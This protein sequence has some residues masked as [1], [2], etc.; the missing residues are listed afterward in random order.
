MFVFDRFELDVP[1]YELRRAGRKVRLQR[2]PMD[3]LILLVE[4]RGALVTR[5]E[6][7][8]RIWSADAAVDSQSSINTAIRK[9]RQALG[10]DGE[11]PRFVETVVGKGYRFI[12]D[13]SACAQQVEAPEGLPPIPASPAASRSRRR[14]MAVAAAGLA[15]TL[16]IAALAGF[17]PALRREP[18]PLRILPFSALR[19]LESWPTFSPDGS[20]VAFGWAEETSQ[21]SHLY[22]QPIDGGSPVALTGG[23]DS[24]TSPSWS[25][26][27]RWI[28]FLRSFSGKDL[29]SNV[30]L[31]VMPASGGDGRRIAA[32]A[33]PTGY[34][35]SWTPDGQG[36]VVMDS[37][38][39]GAPPSLY[40]V[41]L[42]SGQKRRITTA[43]ATGT[44][45][46]CPAFSPD[47]RTLA[48]LRNT[49]SRRLSPL[50]V[51]GVTSKGLP[52]G[53]PRQIE[54]GPTEFAD[55]D[56]SADGRSLIC[57]TPSGLV[58]QPVSG[59]PA[60][61]LPFPGGSQPAVASRGRRLVY[62]QPFRDTDI[63]RVP[64]P[65]ASGVVTKLVSSTREEFAPQYSSDGKRVVFISDRTGSLEVW[66]AD[67]DGRNA[68]QVTSSG[69]PGLGSPRWSPDGQWIAFDSTAGDGP[70]IYVVPSDGGAAR[71]ITSAARGCVRPSWSHDGK[72]IYFGSGQGGVWNI[73]K[74]T[75]QGKGFVQVTRK[76]GRE[77]F[78]DS[79]GQYLYYT[80]TPPTKGIW[81][82]PTAGGE[83]ENV[84]DAGTQGHWAVGGRGI[85]DMRGP[86]ELEFQEFSTMRRLP[87]A[88]PGLRLG[89]GANNMIAAAPDD[90]WI[91]LTVLMRSE[92][93]LTLVQNF[94]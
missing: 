63:F 81:R 43:E 48:F 36:L 87:L 54:S 88:T 50:Y 92:A 53:Q 35:P 65:G 7:A 34:R 67:A 46:W 13:V 89:V 5:E 32:L 23:P 39:P 45:D 12:G 71:R 10:D 41:D 38:L 90:R 11:K 91:L 79:S 9:I 60:E 28:A 82:I 58:R 74:T 22:I 83:E 84:S 6:I 80:K 62:V 24:D 57:T 75:P 4:R 85:Y 29:D 69:G 44:G 42:D 31:Y 20:R 19:G 77:A 8:S 51:M 16:T 25:H 52:A 66:V 78:E 21:S 86:E 93:D 64:G 40:R 26:D 37:E 15:G 47:G 14:G 2:I 3:L 61:P 17:L 72:W 1:G 30:A 56:W 33:G 70:G 18:V 55:F 49:G 76:G 73:W 59:G 68:R 94:K 27:G